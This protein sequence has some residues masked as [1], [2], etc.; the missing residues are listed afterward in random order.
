MKFKDYI[1][2]INYIKHKG[3]WYHQ[4]SKENVI[5]IFDKGGFEVYTGFGN[6]RFT[7]GIY[8]L[9]HPEGKFGDITLEIKVDGKFL[10]LS[11]DQ[12]G[13]IWTNLKKKY[14]AGN[15]KKL[16]D[17]IKKDFPK[18]QGIIFPLILVAWYP[19]KVF[20]GIK[21]IKGSIM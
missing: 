10:D 13:D 20:K 5:G 18:A 16:T 11:N 21:I 8:L 19:N 2:E 3:I 1:N 4:T 6:Q 9:N 14:W 17:S 7:E 12:L 15:W